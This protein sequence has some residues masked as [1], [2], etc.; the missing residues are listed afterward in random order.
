MHLSICYV[1]ADTT[2]K[3]SINKSFRFVLKFKYIL[4]LFE[5]PEILQGLEQVFLLVQFDENIICEL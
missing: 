4:R 3:R 2:N 5:Y 1:T